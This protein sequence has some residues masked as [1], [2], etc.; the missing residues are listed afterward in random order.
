MLR[1]ALPL[2]FGLSPRLRVCAGFLGPFALRLSR[3]RVS[4]ALSCAVP[5]W[6]LLERII[7]SIWACCQDFFL[8]LCFQGVIRGFGVWWW[9]LVGVV[10][11]GEGNGG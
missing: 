1:C 8:R 5:Y 7:E 10:G 3:S 9:Q 11:W 6:T 4:V 2:A